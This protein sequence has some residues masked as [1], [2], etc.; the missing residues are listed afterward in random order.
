MEDK[1]INEDLNEEKIA[2][3]AVD[4]QYVKAMGREVSWDIRKNADLYPSGWSSISN[5]KA[6]IKVL[7]KAIEKKCKISETSGYRELEER[8][9][10]DEE[11]R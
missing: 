8:V 10:T 7:K 11:G 1:D 5:T 6:K 9:I 2:Y 3:L 4:V